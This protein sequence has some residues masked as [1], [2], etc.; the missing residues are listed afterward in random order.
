VFPEKFR[1]HFA[2]GL[3]GR[4]V[5]P[6][7]TGRAAVSA[8]F[9]GPA[10]ANVLCRANAIASATSIVVRFIACSCYRLRLGITSERPFH[11]TIELFLSA[12]VARQ[13]V[14]ISQSLICDHRTRFTLH[15]SPL[16]S[17]VLSGAH[18]VELALLR[19]FL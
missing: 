3:A 6:L 4:M 15:H 17:A 12:I 2:M 13:A 8:K 14:H 9:I 18:I 5:V 19:D 10:N 16:V 11:C 7:T 1:G